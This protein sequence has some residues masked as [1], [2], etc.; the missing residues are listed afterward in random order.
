MGGSRLHG[1][2]AVLAVHRRKPVNNEG[3]FLPCLQ[4]A[5]NGRSLPH[6]EASL[7]QLRMEPVNGGAVLEKN[8]AVPV[9]GQYRFRE[10]AV[11]RL[12]QEMGAAAVAWETGCDRIRAARRGKGNLGIIFWNLLLGWI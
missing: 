10:G 9:Q 5:V 12:S 3:A 6:A 11:L 2:H 8:G 4:R 7:V 1:M